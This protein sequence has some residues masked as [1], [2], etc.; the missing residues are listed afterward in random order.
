MVFITFHWFITILYVKRPTQTLRKIIKIET[1]LCLNLPRGNVGAVRSVSASGVATLIAFNGFEF[2]CVHTA[3]AKQNF[4]VWCSQA[5]T[6]TSHRSSGLGPPTALGPLG[7]CPC[8]NPPLPVNNAT[9][10]NSCT[11]LSVRVTGPVRAKIRF[12]ELWR[13]G[14]KGMTLTD[15]MWGI[16]KWPHLRA[17]NVP[18]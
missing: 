3:S 16:T 9:C 7:M 10:A 13:L 18:Q 14:P 6:V 5:L 4:R 15:V 11:R 1:S 12:G 8:G 17:K 2:C